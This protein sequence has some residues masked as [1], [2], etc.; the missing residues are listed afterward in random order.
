MKKGEM[1]GTCS[2]HNG[3]EKYVVLAGK[4][5]RMFTLVIHMSA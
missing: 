1:G 2:T 5:Q 3:Y 4:L